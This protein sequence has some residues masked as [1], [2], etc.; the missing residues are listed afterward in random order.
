MLVN[1]N[2]AAV[3]MTVQ[4]SFCVSGFLFICFCG[5]FLFM[6]VPVAYGSSQARG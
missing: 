4:I 1:V 3:N 6:A 5:L 2:G